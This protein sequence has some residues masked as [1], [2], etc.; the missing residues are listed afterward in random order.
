MHYS[1]TINPGAHS[2]WGIEW[3]KKDPERR[4]TWILVFLILLI[5]YLLLILIPFPNYQEA[6]VI[7]EEFF[8]LVEP[9]A[10]PEFKSQEKT[11]KPLEAEPEESQLS[12]QKIA[13][14]ITSAISDLIETSDVGSELTDLTEVDIGGGGMD[15]DLEVPI[16][17]PTA[18]DFSSGAD[19]FDGESGDFSALASGMEGLMATENTPGLEGVTGTGLEL[20]AGTG[21]GAGGGIG[22]GI[23]SEVGKSVGKETGVAVALKTYSE[24]DYQGEDILSPLIEWMK[25][26]PARHP[27]AVQIHLKNKTGDLTSVVDF[28]INGVPTEMYLQCTESTKEL[29]ICIVQNDKTIKLVDQGIS[30]RSHKFEEGNAIRDPSDNHIAILNTTTKSPTR[31]VTNRFMS[32]FL[33][34]WNDG[35]PVTE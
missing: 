9:E 10:P 7:E 5:T 16:D 15:L 2:F 32:I 29:A 4:V 34:W 25:K 11:D 19:V 12:E 21:G 26:H 17:L 24:A 28:T 27:K 22:N 13:D 20:S 1:N 35:E 8:D 30:E 33:T 3:F 31:E 14:E 18:G 6:V 23:G